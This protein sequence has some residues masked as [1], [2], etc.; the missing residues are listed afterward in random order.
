MH[1]SANPYLA[2]CAAALC[3]VACGASSASQGDIF[4]GDGGTL[5]QT[6]RG[7]G[8]ASGSG[9]SSGSSG[10]DTTSGSSG[11]GSGSGSVSGGSG[12]SGT[13]SG[14]TGGACP[15]SCA[16]DSDC[17]NGCPAPQG[18]GANCCDTGSGVCFTATT[19]SCPSSGAD[20]AVE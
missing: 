7:E 4:G 15:T 19:S 13:S 16:S 20:A 14:S 6:P 2:L 12:S 18:G 3:S 9:S 8:G 5:S 10:S 11:G 1:M 17:Q